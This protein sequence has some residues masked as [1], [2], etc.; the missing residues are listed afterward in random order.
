MVQAHPCFYTF[1]HVTFL[2]WWY[3]HLNGRQ[4]R[5][6]TFPWWQKVPLDCATVTP[7]DERVSAKISPCPWPSPFQTSLWWLS[8]SMTQITLDLGTLIGFFYITYPRQYLPLCVHTLLLLPKRMPLLQSLNLNNFLE[9]QGLH[10]VCECIYTFFH[11][12]K[13][14]MK[15]FQFSNHTASDLGDSYGA[16]R[17]RC[18]LPYWKYFQN[19]IILGL[20][21]LSFFPWEKNALL[22]NPGIF[23]SMWFSPA[24]NKNTVSLESQRLCVQKGQHLCV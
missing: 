10:T 12:Q 6:K 19:Y 20:K 11:S 17:P 22:W 5:Y 8:P 24:T 14:W 18:G 7:S 13:M 2:P 21:K 1:S 3:F 16:S 9:P 15:F 23:C 4:C